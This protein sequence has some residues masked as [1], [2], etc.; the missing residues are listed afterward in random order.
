MLGSSI[1]G[2]PLVLQ[3]L[4]GEATALQVLG[5]DLLLFGKAF[6]LDSDHPLIRR[7]SLPE[8]ISVPLLLGSSWFD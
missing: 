7:D 6:E 8:L 3:P 1:R 4:Q 5:Q 2:L